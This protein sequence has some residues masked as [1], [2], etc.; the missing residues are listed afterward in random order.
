MA[1]PPRNKGTGATWTEL[2]DITSPRVINAH[3]MMHLAQTRR[4]AGHQKANRAAGAA[5]TRY[6]PRHDRD[7]WQLR[8]DLFAELEMRSICIGQGAYD[9][10]ACAAPDGSNALCDAWWSVADSCLLNGWAGRN[11]W[12][13]P[14][15]RAAQI[16]NTLHHFLGCWKSAPYTTSATFVLPMWEDQEWF[17]LVRDQFEEV[18]RFPAGSMLF[19]R[20]PDVPGDER[21]YVGPTKWP[22]IIVESAGWNAQLL[23]R[24]WPGAKSN[25]HQHGTQKM[26]RMRLMESLGSLQPTAQRA[27]KVMML[28]PQWRNK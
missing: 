18:A 4:V 14:V 15:Y 12:C 20:P 23:H 8:A 17:Q 1:N 24:E 22:V 5:R 7:N 28:L 27:R 25:S 3:K 26:S 19:S 2:G 10:D 6:E 9:V 16:T 13:N 21:V 11:I